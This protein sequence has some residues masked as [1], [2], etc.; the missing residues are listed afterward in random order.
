M[1]GCS[2]NVGAKVNVKD[3]QKQLDM[4]TAKITVTPVMNTKGIQTGTI[5]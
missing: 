3:V 4:T 2:L 5:S 1:E